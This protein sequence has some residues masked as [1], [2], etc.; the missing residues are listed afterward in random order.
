MICLKSTGMYPPQLTKFC[1]MRF[2]MYPLLI[3]TWSPGMMRNYIK[4]ALLLKLCHHCTTNCSLTESSAFVSKYVCSLK[5]H[6]RFLISA[7]WYIE[8]QAHIFRFHIFTRLT[9]VCASWS[10]KVRKIQNHHKT[11]QLAQYSK[12]IS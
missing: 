2:N 11:F 12:I 10:V 9:F 8:Y 5:Y 4:R 7:I 3:S 6:L 1:G